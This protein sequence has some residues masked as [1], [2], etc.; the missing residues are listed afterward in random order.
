M[1]A[2]KT[3]RNKWLRS[4]AGRRFDVDGAYGYQCKDLVDAYCV[5]LWGSWVKTVR[6]GNGKDVFNNANPTYFRKIKNKWAKGVNPKR[7]DV[8]SYGA[9]AAVPE[10]H[11]AVVLKATEKQ[12][13]VVQQDGYTQ[14]AA[15]VRNLGYILPNGAKMLGW[16]RPYLN[17]TVKGKYGANVRTKPTTKSKVEK[18]WK[19]SKAFKYSD[20]V[21]GERV[22]IG[23]TV[24]NKW[25][26]TKEG[27]YIWKPLVKL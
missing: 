27:Y 20:V 6:P 8:V 2:T 3:A 1:P 4:A 23:T 24:S 10:G 11:T 22:R 17:A 14:T 18:T 12:V 16:L 26:R 13:T 9:S 21:T 15:Q 25:V 7:G 5:A 19:P